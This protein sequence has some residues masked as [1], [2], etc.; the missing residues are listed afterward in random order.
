MRDAFDAFS[1][2]AVSKSTAGA[3]QMASLVQNQRQEVLKG[4]LST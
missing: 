1:G 2:D 4:I 3:F